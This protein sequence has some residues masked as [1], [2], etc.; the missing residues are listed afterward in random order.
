MSTVSLSQYMENNI[1]ISETG[2]LRTPLEYEALNKL[3]CTVVV[4]LLDF[5][6]VLLQDGVQSVQ[7]LNE[8][9]IWCSEMH[10]LILQCVLDPASVGFDIRDTEV[11]KHLPSRMN[12]VLKVMKLK[13]PNTVSEAF[14]QN[15]ENCL[16][17]S[18]YNVLQTF[19]LPLAEAD[20]V[21]LRSRHII[22]GLQILQ[23]SGWLSQC[24]VVC[25]YFSFI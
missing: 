24:S 1:R 12:E 16:E 25:I 4:R 11:T 18:Q 2:A 10:K 6:S 23:K 9:S 20:N 17:S 14:I 8:Y 3:K 15:L 21:P 19:A 22:E 7:L 13:V 5:V